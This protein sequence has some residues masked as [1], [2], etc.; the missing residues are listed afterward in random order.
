MDLYV[1][2][3]NILELLRL[4]SAIDGEI[5]DDAVVQATIVTVT[6]VEVTGQIWPVTMA[7]IGSGLGDYRAVLSEDIGVTAN[8]RYIV[9]IDVDGGPNRKA[10]WEIPVM[11]RV[12]DR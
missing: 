7:P 4:K 10:H 1:G 3:N 5:I 12:R 8:T 11:A 2:N 9:I 6:G